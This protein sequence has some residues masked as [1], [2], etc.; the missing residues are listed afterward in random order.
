MLLFNYQS[1]NKTD[2]LFPGEK[3]YF[4]NILLVLILL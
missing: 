3:K 2:L 1:L 4:F